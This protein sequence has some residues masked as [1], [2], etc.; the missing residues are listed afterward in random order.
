MRNVS[1]GENLHKLSGENKK[2]AINLSS[3]EFAQI[4]LE[5]NR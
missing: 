1:N 3:A 2:D 4:M 5:V